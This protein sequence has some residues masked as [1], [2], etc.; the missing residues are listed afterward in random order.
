M[1]IIVHTGSTRAH[2]GAAPAALEFDSSGDEKA[3]LLLQADGSAAAAKTLEEECVLIVRHALLGSEGEPWQRLDG[4]LKELNGL[5]KGLLLG[6]TLEDI[7]AIVAIL[8]RT[9]TLHASHAGRG[10]A[11]LIRNALA[12]QIT[13]FSKGKPLAAFVHISSGQLEPGDLV[14]MG[15]QRLLRTFTPAQLASLQGRNDAVEEVVSVLESEREVAAVA[16]VRVPGGED[17]RGTMMLEQTPP[18]MRPMPARGRMQRRRGAG[19]ALPDMGQTME[20]LKSAGGWLGGAAMGIGRTSMRLGKKAGQRAG[21]MDRSK[22]KMPSFSG[23]TKVMRGARERVEGF[24]ADLRDPHRKRR[25]HLLLLA[26]AV[27]LFLIIW[28]IVS[29][30]TSS[31]RNKSRA[32]LSDL[33]TQINEDIRMADTRKLA[34]DAEGADTILLRAEERAK[35]VSNNESGL[36][37]VEALDLLD[38][39]RQK[40]EELNN[41]VRVS[42]RVVVNLSSKD[43]NVSAQGLLGV[44]DGE[45]LVYDQ[46]S[47]YRVVLSRLDE[48]RRIADE[49]LL[50]QGANFERFKSQVFMTTGNSVVELAGNQLT[51]MKTDDP[52]GWI[53]GNDIETYLR[54]LYVLAPDRKQ[55]YKYERLGNRYGAP[56]P[57][58]VN[59]ELSDALDMTIDGSVYV[60]R[61]GGVLLKLLR[62]ESQPFKLLSAPENVLATATKVTKIVDGNFYFLDP[63]NKRVII[64]GDGGT[65]GE[66]KYLKQYIFEGEQ[67][68]TLQDLYVDPEQR[69]LYLID[70]KRLYVVDLTS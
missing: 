17:T 69:Q 41:I 66:S 29:L 14:L 19:F 51:T 15:T 55:I 48:P 28:L 61:K 26:G 4:T 39:I 59:G 21:T 56:S 43:P 3:F 62:G 8:D 57:Y 58:N 34:G 67:L 2:N 18:R 38:R 45:F 68:G 13:E 20:M 40:R 31:L 42:P 24:V 12:A 10:E 35:Q 33:V 54:Y 6:Q 1:D 5:F 47:G 27:A 65:A 60:L 52:D 22:M 64:T 49:E 11:Y 16:S 23:V 7:H 53:T 63:D 70:E 9:G 37:S 25:A 30:T 46:R 36:F 44:G 50:V 32:E